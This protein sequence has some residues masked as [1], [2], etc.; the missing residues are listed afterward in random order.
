MTQGDVASLGSPTWP[1]KQ[2]QSRTPL[3]IVPTLRVGMQPG[4]LRVPES[5]TQS[6]RRGIPTRSVGT[7]EAEGAGMA[8]ITRQPPPNALYNATLACTRANLSCTF[9]SWAAYSVR[10]VS[11]T[12]SKSSA[13]AW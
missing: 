3:L 12:V 11:S 6:V 7:I 13:P 10:W 4:T 2:S 9:M 5:R 1:D 8:Y